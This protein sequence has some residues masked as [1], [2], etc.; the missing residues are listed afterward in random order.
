VSEAYQSVLLESQSPDPI[1]QTRKNDIQNQVSAIRSRAK[2]V[3]ML[4]QTI[5]SQIEEAYKKAMAD[6][7][8]ITENKVVFYMSQFRR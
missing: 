2:A 4:R 3:Q 1:L 6:I 5:E 8:K 7:E